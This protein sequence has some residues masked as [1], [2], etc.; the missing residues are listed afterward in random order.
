MRTA[1][2]IK[3]NI[4]ENDGDASSVMAFMPNGDTLVA[5]NEHPKFKA[6]LDAL[7]SGV[8]DEEK[9]RDLFDLGHAIQRAFKHL[10]ERVMIQNNI[11]YF[12]GEP[13]RSSLADAIIRFYYEGSPFEPLVL[14]ME[15]VK[16]NPNEH[17]REQL[18]DWMQK[19]HFG[20]SET[21]DI[22]AFK[23]VN[24]RGGEADDEVF[25]SVHAG[26]AWVNGV[27]HTGQIP[28]QPGTVVEMPRNKVNHNP[29]EGCSTGLHAGTHSYASSFAPVLLRVSINPRDVVS[30]PTDCN[31]DKMRV[32]RYKVLG[33]TN[34]SERDTSALFVKDHL[35]ELTARSKA[36][37]VP[38][39][40][41][42]VPIKKESTGAEINKPNRIKGILDQ[43]E[44]AAANEPKNAAKKAAAK[45]AS[46]AKVA[47]RK[48]AAK[49]APAKKAPAKKT[50]AK[51]TPAK[52]AAKPAKATSTKKA[53]V[54]KTATK[55]VAVKKS[56]VDSLPDFYEQFSE[57]QFAA[58]DQKQRV[59]LAKEWDCVPA[60]RTN[61]GYINALT[62]FAAERRKKAGTRA[63]TPV[64]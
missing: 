59:W 4:T 36:A 20:I 3:Y 9:I 53:A 12:D 40:T 19:Q 15:K 17:S 8:D 52:T 31:G 29:R 48:V 50:P 18:F 13:Q 41:T 46:L 43:A 21:G 57:E 38:R 34:R 26:E 61:T 16:T 37:D 10:S 39:Q 7:N 35:L 51:K 33:R 63:A 6:I 60:V 24:S 14:F 28:T 54:S 58:M 47:A 23:G 45:K 2:L 5:T 55:K 44:K 64:M 25:R 27:L 56:A 11:I 30:V 42:K 1:T 32:C 62:R 49:T 22:V